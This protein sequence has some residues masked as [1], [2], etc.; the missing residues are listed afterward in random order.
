MLAG[1]RVLHIFEERELERFFS[2]FLR[3]GSHMRSVHERLGQRLSPGEKLEVFLL[4]AFSPLL[5]VLLPFVLHVSADQFFL[6]LSREL[7]PWRM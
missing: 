2:V 7:I 4:V 5:L 3:M 6:V 1:A